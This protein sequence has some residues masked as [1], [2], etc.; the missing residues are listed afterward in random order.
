MAD[1]K[2]NPR[3]RPRI[4]PTVP[5]VEQE[6]KKITLTNLISHRVCHSFRLPNQDDYF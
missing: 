4:P 1:I 3:K 6:N 5:K 2:L